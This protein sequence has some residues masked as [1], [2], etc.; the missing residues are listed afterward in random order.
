MY[1]RWLVWRALVELTLIVAL[2]FG[3]CAGAW[4]AR[5]AASAYEWHVLGVYVLS[6][7][8]LT[9]GFHP[10]KTKKMRKED[11]TVH[12]Y[13]IGLI[14]THEP[15]H[16]LRDRILGDLGRAVLHGAGV[17]VGILIGTLLGVRVFHWRRRRRQEIARALAT[18]L[19]LARQ[20]RLLVSRVVHRVPAIRVSVQFMP[21]ADAGSAGSSHAEAWEG[22]GANGNPHAAH[23]GVTAT[24]KR[25]GPVP[26]PR[27][28]GKA[29]GAGAARPGKRGREIDGKR[30][31]SQPELPFGERPPP[32]GPSESRRSASS[33]GDGSRDRNKPCRDAAASNPRSAGSTAPNETGRSDE[34]RLPADEP[35]GKRKKPRRGSQDFY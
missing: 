6:E 15:I 5:S 21:R 4:K 28:D 2:I 8:L 34:R 20:A 9:L 24:T 25:R 12:V 27:Q 14:A 13:T 33:G 16:T 23:S 31:V 11:G 17:G 26:Q 19:G 32:P 1:P 7:T 18:T 22:S 30:V 29:M 35:A 10:D 3:L